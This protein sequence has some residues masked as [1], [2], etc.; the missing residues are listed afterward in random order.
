[1]PLSE[2]EQRILEEIE[3]SLNK[4]DLGLA[5]QVRSSAAYREE[6]RNALWAIPLALLGMAVI[7]A[8]LLFGIYLIGVVGFLLS[9]YALLVLVNGIGRVRKVAQES[10]KERVE[11]WSL[12]QMFGS[13]PVQRDVDESDSPGF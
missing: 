7:V 10:L 11:A 5:G 3:E 2:H 13:G 9:V 4:R 1:M 8:S 12:R 6:R